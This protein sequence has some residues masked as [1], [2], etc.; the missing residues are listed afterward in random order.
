MILATMNPSKDVVRL[1]I[2]TVVPLVNILVRN[3][4][5]NQLNTIFA[6]CE[7]K[8]HFEQQKRQVQNTLKCPINGLEGII[9]PLV[10]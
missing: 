10:T 6:C 7:R 2:I 8:Q 3:P 9:D 4:L 1:K 5:K